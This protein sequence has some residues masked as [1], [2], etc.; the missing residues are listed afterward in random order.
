MS[1]EAVFLLLSTPEWVNS[2]KLGQLIQF[3]SRRNCCFDSL[4]S[5]FLNSIN[6][7]GISLIG[8]TSDILLMIQKIKCRLW[9]CLHSIFAPGFSSKNHLTHHCCVWITS[10]SLLGTCLSSEMWTSCWDTVRHCFLDAYPLGCYCL[11]H[12]TAQLYGRWGDH[13]INGVLR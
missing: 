8:T 6:P 3:S 13:T 12:T 2:L 1:A 11:T 10:V 9:L 7:V 4:F 5:D